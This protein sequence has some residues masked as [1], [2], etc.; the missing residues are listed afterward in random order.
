MITF[1][2]CVFFSSQAFY[3]T[4][5]R[6]GSTPAGFFAAAKVVDDDANCQGGNPGDN[7]NVNQYLHF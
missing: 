7:Q 3:L 2:L 5:I 4:V 1:Y 6:A